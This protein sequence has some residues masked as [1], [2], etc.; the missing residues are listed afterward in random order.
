MKNTKKTLGLTTA[1]HKEVE[2]ANS[3]EGIHTASIIESLAVSGWELASSSQRRAYKT[4]VED[5]YHVARLKHKTYKT[6]DGD[7]I[8]LVISNSHD[9]SSSFKVNIGVFRLVCSNGLV[10]G[11]NLLQPM[12]IPHKGFLTKVVPELIDLYMAKALDKV[13]ESIKKM[14]E[15]KLSTKEKKDLAEKAFYLKHKEGYAPFDLVQLYTPNRKEDNGSDLW[16]IYNVIQENL[17]HGIYD[18]I[19][20]NGKGRKAKKITSP[21]SNLE[22]NQKLHDLAME[23]VV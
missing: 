3:Y 8:E 14:Q 10:L 9:K 19:G 13:E 2:T 17:T 21:M 4:K 11:E 15:K 16:S 7:R 20:A 1:F 22:I 12:I 18:I 23:K 6:I 5:A